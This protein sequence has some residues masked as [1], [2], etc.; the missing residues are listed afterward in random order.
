MI[1]FCAKTCVFGGGLIIVGSLIPTRQLIAQLPKG[2]TRNCWY[3]MLMLEVL[4]LA[5]YLGYARVFWNDHSGLHDLIVPGVFFLGACF[6]W[7]AAALSL[8]TVESIARL[9]SLEQENIAD[10]LTGVFNRR[11]LDRCLNEEVMRARRFDLPLSILLLDIDHFKK[12]NDSYG[13]RAGDQVLISFAATVQMKLREFDILARYGGDEFMIIAPQTPPQ[14]AANLATRLRARIEVEELRLSDVQGR[15]VEI[16]LT[17]SMGVASLVG[18]VDSAEKLINAADEGL[19]RV[20]RKEND[21]VKN[22]SGGQNLLL[23]KRGEA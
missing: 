16:P 20:K 6:V 5:G 18:E 17:C 11:Y 13:H 23:G 2:Y 22:P 14:G 4:F 3:A 7:L 19:Y 21:R 10:A 12:I 8:Q 1:S 9:N 15:T